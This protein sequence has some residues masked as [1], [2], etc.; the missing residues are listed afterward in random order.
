MKKEKNIHPKTPKEKVPMTPDEEK[1]INET[2][3][4]KLGKKVKIIKKENI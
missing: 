4:K 3:Q 1:T 2:L